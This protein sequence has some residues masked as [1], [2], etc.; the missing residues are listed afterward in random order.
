M[1]N[2][3][4]PTR[5]SAGAAL[6]VL[7]AFVVG[8]PAVAAAQAPEGPAATTVATNVT[9]EEAIAEAT[10]EHPNIA[11][12]RA[13]RRAAEAQRKQARANFG[14]TLSA[15][16]GIQFWNDEITFSTSPG[17]DQVPQLPPP[18]TPYEEIIAGLFTQSEPTVVRDQ[19][20][21]DVALTISQPLGPLYSIYHGYRA[22]E[23]AEEAAEEQVGQVSRDQAREAAVA[24]FRVLQA[25]A[26]L[27]TAQ[28]SVEQLAAQVETVSVLVEAGATTPS[29]RMRIEV[30]LAA[31]EQEVIQARSRVRLAQSNLAVALGRNAQER[32][33][34]N[35]VDADTLPGVAGSPE[36][37]VEAAVANR[38]ELRQL[39]L[40]IEA[41]ESGVKAEEGTYIPQLVAVGQYSHTEG[42][43]LA[44]TDTAFVGLSLDWTLWQWGARYYAVDEAEAQV[45]S[46]EAT[47]EQTRRQIGLQAKMAWYDL[48]SAVEAYG[49]AERAVAQAEEAYRVESVRYE[50]GKSTSTDL[51]DA[52]SALT[53]ARNNRNN[54][55]YQALI[56]HTELIYATG[57]PVTADRLL[58]GGNR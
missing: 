2:R 33:G 47:Q 51:L 45:V 50:A 36:D 39:E 26:I 48:E 13:D 6:A 5:L 4:K 43:G 41:A 21:W 22:T 11:R 35:A 3:T 56:Q 25:Q 27:E 28:Q 8:G 46:L 49:V 14:P 32:V 58:R 17:G 1:S 37:A 16:A 42:Q 55:L 53:E 30:A 10:G 54:A 29:Q 7:V 20:T 34:A 52:Q 38:P 44:G 12:A 19:V 18:Q 9:L 23:F 40:G 57:R 15:S 31:A 24:Y